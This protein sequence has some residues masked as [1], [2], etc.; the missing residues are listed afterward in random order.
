[1][2]PVCHLATEPPPTLT[3]SVNTFFNQLP[4]DIEK[5]GK[6]IMF[7]FLIQT[8]ELAWVIKAKITNTVKVKFRNKDLK[9]QLNFI[10]VWKHTNIYICNW[11]NYLNKLILYTNNQLLIMFWDNDVSPCHCII[12]NL[13]FNAQ[14]K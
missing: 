7:P 13:H 14:C 9:T 11:I 10:T 2:N 4:R 1:M 3:H 6:I 5:Y 12:S 8:T